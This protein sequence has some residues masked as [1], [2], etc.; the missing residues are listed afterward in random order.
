[1]ECPT[2]ATSQTL[3]VSI[4]PVSALCQLKAFRK[5]SLQKT[6]LAI[7]QKKKNG[8]TEEINFM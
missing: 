5:Q 6:S 1:M 3:E 2:A 7:F 8:D 4:R